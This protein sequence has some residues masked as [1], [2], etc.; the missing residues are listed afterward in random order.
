M[1]PSKLETFMT[2]AAVLSARSTCARKRV[3][4]IIL[5]THW[6]IVGSGYNGPAAGLTHCTSHPCPGATA[7]SGEG[8]KCEALHAEWNALLQCPDPY[9]IETAFVTTSPCTTC[10]KML[11]NT[12]CKKIYYLRNHHEVDASRRLWIDN[13]RSMIRLHPA[14]LKWAE[15]LTVMYPATG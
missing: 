10:V 6:H 9:S 8:Y 4:C 2:L 15:L 1:R 7:P 3:G 14:S 13:E 5:D 11:M 12:S